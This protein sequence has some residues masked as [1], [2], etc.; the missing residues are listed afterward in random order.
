MN[1]SFIRFLLVGVINTIVGL[2]SMYTLLHFVGLS[3]WPATFIGNSIG[4]AVS[5][6]LNKTFTFHSE[7]RVSQ[8]WYRFM[9]VIVV[10]YFISFYIG[11]NAVIFVMERTP[12]FPTSY[13]NDLAILV[14]AGLYTISNYLG[15]RLFVFSK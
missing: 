4:A 8:T 7:Q 9:I 11:K 6:F 13:V 10:C 14:G 12:Q 3:Y 1:H 5:Y 15:Q 2:T